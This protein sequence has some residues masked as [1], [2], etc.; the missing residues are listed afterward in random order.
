MSLRGNEIEDEALETCDWLLSHENYISW[1]RQHNGLLWIKG[2]PGAG[3]STLM[4]YAIRESQQRESSDKFVIASFFVHGR[5]APIQKN[6]LGLY[7]SL[8]HQILDQIPELLSEFSSIFRKRRESEGEPGK[9]WN[10]HAAELKN[11]FNTALPRIPKTYTI[12]IYVDALDECGEANAKELVKH[13]DRL[14]SKLSS[15]DTNVSICFSCRHF[16]LVALEHG[17]TIVV[18][19]EN[20][21]DILRYV[22]DQLRQGFSDNIKRQDLE[23]E[24]VRKASG[25]FQWVVLVVATMLRLSDEGYGIRRIQKKLQEIPSELHSLYQDILDSIKKRDDSSQSLRLMQWVCFAQRPLSLEE[26]RFA[27]IIDADTIYTTLK[28]CTESEA[29][30]ESNEQMRKWIKVLSGGLIEVEKRGYH[31]IAQFIHQSVNDYLIQSGLQSFDSSLTNSV[32]GQA[33]FQ[34]SRSC[35]KYIAMKEIE[36][37]SVEYGESSSS[38]LEREFP[39]LKYSITAWYSHAEI[40]EIEKIRQ[41]DLLSLFQR[42]SNRILQCWIHLYHILDYQSDRCPSAKTTLLHVASRYCL[43]SLVEI[44]LNSDNDIN[45]NSEDENGQTPLL[46]AARKG[47]EAVVRL[48][49]EQDDVKA[50][51]KDHY[52]ETPLSW[53]AYKGHDAVVRLLLP[54]DDVKA[55]SKDEYGRTPLSSAAESGQKGVVRLLLEQDDV[56]ADSRSTS[57]RTPLSSAAESGHEAVVQLL[58]K[59]EDVKADSKDE[60]GQTPLWWAAKSGH[61]AVVRLLL[62]QD[63]VDANYKDDYGQTP[64]LW[65]AKSG[66][67]ALVRVLLERDDVKADSKDENG[68]TPLLWAAR[69][70]HEALVRILLERDDVEVNSKDE[71]GRTPLSWAAE[72]GHDAVVRLLLEKN[73]VEADS[74]DENG[75]TPLSSAAESGHEAVVR[76]LLERYDVKADSKDANGQTPLSRAAKSGNK[77]VVWLLLERDDIKADSKDNGWRTPLLWAAKSGDEAVVRL[78]LE[79]GEAGSKDKNGRTPLWWAAELGHDAVVRLLLER[80]D[81]EV[82]LIDKNGRTLLSRAAKSGNEALVRLLL[83]RDDV[84]VNS[85]DENGRTPLSWAAESGHD[86]VVRLLLEKDDVEADSKDENGRTPLSSAAESGYEAVV[87]LLLERYDVEAD[88][89]DANGRMPLW[90]AVKLGHDAVVRLLLE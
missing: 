51:S 82:S 16:P 24:I 89:K 84:E 23:R 42:P 5:G 20:S 31:H 79:R 87:R 34:L 36:K 32:I 19:D 83:K 69:S 86:A 35:I 74:K 78:L 47:Y 48:L 15:V 49:L 61:E 40:V 71:N 4:K 90:W 21:G 56:K 59:R 55:N 8:L 38:D 29:Y 17:L 67:E 50:D 37:I 62:E 3:K 54:R 88:S 41:E 39:F 18:E 53:A 57:G 12:Q 25:V 27:I 77:A 66:H 46:W 70:G 10:W 26:L 14:T 65:A 68:Q 52:G 60:N 64:L 9:Q 44:I 30:V 43:I 1:F 28:E 76:L 6:S 58:L 7:R 33:H 63:D 22:Q 75:R 73:D 85:K 80:D 11:F 2:K 81:V 13:F 72:S 45:I